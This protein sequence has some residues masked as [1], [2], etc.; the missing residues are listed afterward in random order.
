MIEWTDIASEF[1]D[2]GSLRDIYVF[3]ATRED[4]QAVYGHLRQGPY[5]LVLN[6]GQPL[7]ADVGEM[8][9]WDEVRTL[10]IDPDGLCVHCHFFCENE[11]EFDIHPGMVRSQESL[12]RLCDFMMLIG[13]AVCKDV[14]LTPE[15][16]PN[17]T[18]LRYDSA[19]DRMVR[20]RTA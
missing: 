9:A 17:W 13:R 15:N 1:E 18:I 12:D 6:G 7:P 3:A 4:W 11:I 8:M 2:D 10:Q 14:L 19:M 16:S 5:R 20:E